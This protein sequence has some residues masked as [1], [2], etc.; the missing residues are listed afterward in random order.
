MANPNDPNDPMYQGQAQQPV[1]PSNPLGGLHLLEGV[2]NVV[3]ALGYFFAGAPNDA[4][5]EVEEEPRRRSFRPRVS[6]ANRPT[7][8]G[9]KP[10][11][12]RPVGG[13]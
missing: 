13:K 5:E 3:T 11:C 4:D 10:C 6:G 9:Q 7:R 2:G 1:A 8:V 12:R